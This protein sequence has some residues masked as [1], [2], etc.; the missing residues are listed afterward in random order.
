VSFVYL[1]AG[2]PF[3]NKGDIEMTLPRMDVPVGIVE[4]ELFAPERYSMKSIGG[5]AI[6][7]NGLRKEGLVE[8][9]I[10]GGAAGT[11]AAGTP[12]DSFDRLGYVRG[13]A[14]DASGA[15]M[16]GVTIEVASPAL[17]ERVRTTVTDASGRFVIANLPSGRMSVTAKLTG[18]ATVVREFDFD[19]R[20][21]ELNI[22]MPVGGL[23]ETVTVT[24]EAP[25]IDL[26]STARQMVLRN[27]SPESL[28]RDAISKIEVPQTVAPSQNIIDLQRKAAG[29]L[30][31]RIDVP[32]AG[33]S[34]Q[35]VKPLVVDQ[36][37]TVRL[38][39]K[40]R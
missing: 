12:A 35:F 9:G 40:R 2:T 24:A 29:V 3:A 16:P 27:D 37:T 22:E 25:L 13:V 28:P 39:Y 10:I 1:H 19:R 5:N 31:V 32:R 8:G 17:T 36:E 20:P 23:T 33:T 6:D 30:P 21:R 15:V 11:F 4:W 38:R 34:H 26:Q 7:V 18:F 14:R